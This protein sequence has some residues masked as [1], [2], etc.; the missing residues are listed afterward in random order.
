LAEWRR[1]ALHYVEQALTAVARNH[2]PQNEQHCAS[3]FGRKCQYL[4][5]CKLPAAQRALKL[6]D[7]AFKDYERGPLGAAVVATQEVVR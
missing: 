7:D 3:H 2:F 5:V 6:A 4:E 1:D